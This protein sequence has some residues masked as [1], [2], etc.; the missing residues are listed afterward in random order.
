MLFPLQEH[1]TLQP[2]T[3][4]L[5]I[6]GIS[7]MFVNIDHDGQIIIEC[8]DAYSLEDLIKTPRDIP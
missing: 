2:E 5:L 4:R 6:C 1:E 7:R 8:W 3:Q